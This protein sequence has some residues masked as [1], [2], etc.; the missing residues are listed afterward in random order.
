[1][2][3]PHAARTLLYRYGSLAWFWR[4]LILL[5]V[6]FGGASAVAAAMGGGGLLWLGAAAMLLPALF[7]GFVVATRVEL[8]D[9][10]L[11]VGTLLGVPRTIALS[12]LGGRRFSSY[13]TADVATQVHAPRLWQFVRGSL[14][15]YL[16]LL[17]AIPDPQAFERVF[18]RHR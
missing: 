12:S 4:P 16:D 2:A 17:A 9:A 10:R 13:A 14:P 3:T 5:G 8:E 15:I 7:F 18:G 6:A 11:R 1:M